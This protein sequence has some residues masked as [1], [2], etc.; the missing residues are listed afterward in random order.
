MQ[1]ILTQ[2]GYQ[3]DRGQ[4]VWQRDGSDGWPHDETASRVIRILGEASDITSSSSELFQQA[5]DDSVRY[6]LSPSRPNLLRPFAELFR[7]RTL[8]IGPGGGAVTRF[9]GEAGGI[10]K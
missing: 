7:G 6:H 2:A 8:E 4:N 5:V 1:S 9:L 10:L 3:Y